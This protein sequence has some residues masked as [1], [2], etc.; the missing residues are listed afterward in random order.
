[1]PILIFKPYRYSILVSFQKHLSSKQQKQH[2]IVC[3]IQRLGKKLLRILYF[4]WLSNSDL[5]FDLELDIQ[6]HSKVIRFLEPIL[7]TLKMESARNTTIRYDVIVISQWWPWIW[8][9]A[10]AD[11]KVVRICLNGKWTKY[12][13]QIWFRNNFEGHGKSQLNKWNL[14]AY[15]YNQERPFIP[16]I[17][18][19]VKDMTFCET[20]HTKS[21]WRN[22]TNKEA[23]GLSHFYYCISDRK[24]RTWEF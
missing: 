10:S 18:D 17:N 12:Y 2:G 1:M 11:L 22:E 16:F 20:P 24:Y 4:P 15:Y 7:L 6:G 5:K 8:S 23:L 14:A 19:S 9:W 21:K 3:N 13:V